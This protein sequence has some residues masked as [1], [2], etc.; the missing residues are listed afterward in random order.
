MTRYTAGIYVGPSGEIHIT[1]Q[2]ATAGTLRHA[3]GTPSGDM[4][5]WKVK[6]IDQD[7]FAGA[8]SRP[9]IVDGKLMLA[10]WWRMGG[11]E[12]KGDVAIVTP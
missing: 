4:I 6:A 5:T 11:D 2:D 10:N 3:V 8:F 1:Y 7:G 9:F 12:P